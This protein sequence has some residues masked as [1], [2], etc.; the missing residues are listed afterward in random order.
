MLL[1]LLLGRKKKTAL[2]MAMMMKR[3]RRRQKHGYAR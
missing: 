1:T 3:F 2:T